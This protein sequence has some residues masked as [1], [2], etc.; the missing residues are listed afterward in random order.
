LD[1][2]RLGNAYIKIIVTRGKSGG[3]L[4]PSARTRP[5]LVIYALPYK[6]SAKNIY[7]KGI[8]VFLSKSGYNEKSKIAGKKTLNYLDNILCRYDAKN[9]NLDDVILTNT[10]GF[11]S[12]ASS[13]NI[14]LV[15]GKKIYTPC[16]ASG[17][18]PGIT[19]EEVI[20]LARKFLKSEV[21][22]DFIKVNTLY[23]ADEIFLTNS[24]VEIMPVFP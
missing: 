21:R 13:S 3:L 22:E 20:S 7:Q 8:R 18:L 17:I 24:L 16:I 12:E 10:K 4:V 5:T 11:V 6:K 19:R 1:K 2:N 14:F 15:K 23:G 9:K